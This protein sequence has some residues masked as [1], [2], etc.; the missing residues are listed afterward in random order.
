MSWSGGKDSALALHALRADPGVE[1]AGLLTTV[2]EDYQRISMH[3][4]RRALLDE[5]A[6]SIGLPLRIVLIPKDCSTGAYE[7]RMRETLDAARADGV[8]AVGIGDIFLEDLRRYREEKL[9]Q[10][11]MQALF[12][13]WKR[14]TRELARAFLDLGFRAVLTCVDTQKLD[15]SFAGREYDAALLADLPKTV[16]P[17]GE[18][19]EFHSCVYAGPIFSRP[20]AFTRGEVVLRDNRFCFCDLVPGTVTAENTESAENSKEKA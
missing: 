1:V 7:R 18:N 11:G 5:Q 16:D 15:R 12:P 3:G 6:R 20:L 17:C 13:L 2:T 4:I 14:D 10:A 19:G 9:A 8:D